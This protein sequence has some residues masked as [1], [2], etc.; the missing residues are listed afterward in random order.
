MV[1]TQFLGQESKPCAECGLLFYRDKRCTYAHW[2][3]AKF[4]SRKCSGVYGGKKARLNNTL[5]EQFE[6]FVIK[7][8]G[9]W[10]WKGAV[11]TAKGGYAI[12][13]WEKK[14]YYGHLV[15]LELD[16]RKVPK[17]MYGCHHCDNP[18]CTNPAHLYVGTAKQNSADAM[19]RGRN[20]RGEKCRSAVLTESL[21]REIRGSEAPAKLWAAAL[22]VSRSNIGMIRT[23]RTWKHVQ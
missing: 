14:Q 11:N 4:C 15:S 7:K 9:C 17:G 2:G 3:R 12:L 23:N 19:A 1:D 20:V 5:Q 13:M 22:G 18:S 16:G 21:V 8:D 10:G 6:R